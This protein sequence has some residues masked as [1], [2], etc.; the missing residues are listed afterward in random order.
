MCAVGH[1]HSTAHRGS[2]P[3]PARPPP[4]PPHALHPHHA[5]TQSKGRR[6]IHRRRNSCPLLLVGV[7]GPGSWFP[8]W[9]SY[10]AAPLRLQRGR[11]TPF[12]AHRAVRAIPR[13][14]ASGQV[15]H[16]GRWSQRLAASE[17]SDERE[18]GIWWVFIATA[19]TPPPSLSIRRILRRVYVQL[20]GSRVRPHHRPVI[21]RGGRGELGQ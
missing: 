8:Y 17:S 18:G 6:A 16:P 12:G 21:A 20:K 15:G 9:R 13:A 1:L 11:A 5:A 3:L 10:I 2:L 7:L 14:Q 19:S 4:P